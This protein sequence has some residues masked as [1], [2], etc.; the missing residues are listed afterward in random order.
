MP[1]TA[2]INNIE[3]EL[4]DQAVEVHINKVQSGRRTPVTEQPRLH[5]LEFQRFAQ[6]RIGEQ[7]D[8][9]NREVIGRTPVGVHLAQL[10]WRKWLAGEGETGRTG[11]CSRSHGKSFSC[12]TVCVTA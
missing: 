1:R 10:S 6:Q 5:M 12:L 9:S 8:L 3:V 11:R 4:L 2:N 7:I